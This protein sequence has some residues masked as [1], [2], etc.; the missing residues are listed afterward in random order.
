[1]T[2][3]F[4]LVAYRFELVAIGP[5]VFSARCSCSDWQV[6]IGEADA[7]RLESLNDAVELAANA[8]SEHVLA[9]VDFEAR[10]RGRDRTF[11]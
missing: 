2:H 3:R 4:E 6:V 11:A 7:Q 8:W 9:R 5:P 1:M 10:A